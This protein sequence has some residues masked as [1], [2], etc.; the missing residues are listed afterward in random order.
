MVRPPP[1]FRRMPETTRP[2]SPGDVDPGFRRGDGGGE[3]L[4]VS[5]QWSVVG[6]N[7]PGTWTPAFAGETGGGGGPHPNLPPSGG[8]LPVFPG[9]SGNPRAPAPRGRGPRLSPGRRG[10]GGRGPRL[11]PGRRGGEAWTPAFAGET[12][13]GRRG[14]RLSPGRRGGGGVDPG[15]RRG[16]GGGGGVDPGF[17]R[18]DGGGGGAGIFLIFLSFPLIFGPVVDSRKGAPDRYH[19]RVW[20]RGLGM[21]KCQWGA[22]HAEGAEITI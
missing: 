21:G 11:S 15:F 9:E 3:W 7:P 5:G 13:G 22:F 10:G 19:A 18:G 6:P 4:V 14:P 1:S 8:S 12:G 16:D 17:R 20:S 2:P